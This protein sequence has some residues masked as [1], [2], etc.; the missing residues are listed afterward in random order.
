VLNFVLTGTTTG[1]VRYLV[2][3]YPIGAAFNPTNAA[4]FDL[5]PFLSGTSSPSVSVSKP[6]QYIY[7][8]SNTLTGCQAMGTVNVLPGDLVADFSPNPST[9]YAPLAVNFQNQSHTS[10]GSGS[11]TSIWSFGNGSSQ[12][13]T[14][15][16]DAA[17]TFTAPG[18]Y[19]VMLLAQKGLCIDTVYKTIKVDMPSKLEVPNVFTPNG[20][21]VNDVF[22]LKVANITEVSAMIFD[23]WGNKVYEVNSST[24]NIAW[25]GKNLQGKD[26]SA[27]TYFYII[28]GT[29]KDDKNYEQKGNVSLYR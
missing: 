17:T 10:L 5:N 11:I 2:S 26:C 28:K 24:G 14:N 16:S 4:V 15:T 19:T 25:D 29:G 20:D 27:G 7:I 12:S 8:V 18:T 1:G 9:G 6:G 3:R 21:G 23:R 13:Y 22:F